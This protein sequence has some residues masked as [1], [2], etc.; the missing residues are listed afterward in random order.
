[1]VPRGG[2]EPPTRGFSVQ[3]TPSLWANKS[4][5]FN[6]FFN[7][8]F[9][10]VPH[11]NLS[12]T[13]RRVILLKLTRRFPILFGNVEYAQRVMETEIDP[14]LPNRTRTLA[15]RVDHPN[16]SSSVTPAGLTLPESGRRVGV[17]EIGP[18]WRRS[19][20]QNPGKFLHRKISLCQHKLRSGYVIL[21]W[22]PFSW[23]Q[24]RTC[25]VFMP[26]SGIRTQRESNL[27]GYH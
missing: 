4:K 25:C 12:R 23:F 14:N 27:P 17:L 15:A 20:R 6:Y 2:I 10:L 1:M 9:V 5:T 3:I 18:E 16:S 22:P 19:S 11:P 24:P 13:C 7:L 21:P 8:I 26:T